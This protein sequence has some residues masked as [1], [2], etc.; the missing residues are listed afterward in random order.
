MFE[1]AKERYGEEELSVAR[2]GRIEDLLVYFALSF[3]DRDRAYSRM[4]KSLQRD[5]KAFFGKPTDAYKH[6]RAA[7]FTIADADKIATACEL[8]LAE[9]DCGRI[10]ASEAYLF[11]AR[12]LDSL[13][14]IL[15]IYVGCGATLYGD[16][17]DV[18]LIKI[19]FNS[20]KLSL[21]SYDDFSKRLP[22]L[23]KRTKI[24]L[25]EQDYEEFF[26]R[27]ENYKQPLYFRSLFLEQRDSDYT[28]QLEFDQLVARVP[29]IKAGELGPD[30]KELAA[31]LAKHQVAATALI[32]DEIST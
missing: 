25:R 15:R 20:G 31:L 6:A 23:T 29:G 22:I 1:L 8:A 10:F 17:Q 4:P 26:Y 9:T 32:I 14:A 19:H 18:D 12:L 13:P 2:V 11:P 16:F 7:L 27:D 30:T 5:I 21:L 24:K 3:F 28:A